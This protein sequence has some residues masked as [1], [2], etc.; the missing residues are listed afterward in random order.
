MSC[1][2]GAD[3]WA[4]GSQSTLVEGPPSTRRM[5]YETK[6]ELVAPCRQLNKSQNQ[7]ALLRVHRRI[8]S[9]SY[10]S[11]GKTTCFAS[12]AVDI[13][14]CINSHGDPVCMW[15]H[16][17]GS[18]ATRHQQRR[19]TGGQDG[20]VAP[21]H[22]PS[23]PTRTRLSSIHSTQLQPS[24]SAAPSSPPTSRTCPPSLPPTL[25]EHPRPYPA[26]LELAI[27]SSPTS[28]PRPCRCL[29]PSIAI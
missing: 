10:L 11:G 1:G 20:S 5:G 25:R 9:C 15:H 7:F 29:L 21:P 14:T 28:A 4:A 19:T 22:H 18:L 16:S 13:S 8:F 27:D 26:A 24:T 23:P 3:G 12:K 6:E 17:P 2:D